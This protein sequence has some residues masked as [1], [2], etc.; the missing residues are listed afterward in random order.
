MSFLRNVWYVAAWADEIANEEMLSRRFLGEK[1]VLFR[2]DQGEAKAIADRCPHRFVPLSAGKLVNGGNAVQCA[3][4]GLQFDGGGA[5][6]CNPHGDRAIPKAAKVHS[7]PLVERYS[8]LWI[9]MGDPAKADP[10]SIPAFP[11]M[12][13]EHWYVGHDYL[14]VKANYTLETDNI[15]DL[16]HIQ[17]LHPGTLGSGNTNE[18]SCQV[19]QEGSTVWSKRFMQN[20]ALPDFLY[21]AIG[22]ARGTPC[23]RWLDVRWDPPS[24]MWLQADI[25]PSGMPREQS[26]R[27]PGAHLFTPESESATHYF[28]SICFP[29]AMGPMGAELAATQVKGLRVPFE[30]EDSPMLE[31]QHETMAGKAFWDQKPVL[32]PMDAPAVRARRVLDEL[33]AAEVA[34]NAG[35]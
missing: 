33:I 1:V 17:Y 27:T 11:F 18:G 12:D 4:H 10:A 19:T 34:A 2:N 16:S 21:D 29:K 24:V 35:S 15:M 28:F 6:V 23:D 30:T 13:P 31:L 32:L 22:I 9:W 14:Y 7:Y 8:L 26:V 20:E 25:G 5:C 3:Y